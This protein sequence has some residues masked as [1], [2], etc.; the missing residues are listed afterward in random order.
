M[1][2]A[3]EPTKIEKPL[4]VNREHLLSAL[5]FAKGGL[6]Q[7]EIIQ[8]STCFIFKD[9]LI[10]TYNEK[11]CCR[12]PSPL[13]SNLT[14]AIPSAPLLEILGELPEEE[15]QVSLKN[16]Q[17]Q[18]KGRG[19]VAKINIEARIYLDVDSIE[20]PLEGAKG[21]GW[22]PLHDDFCEAISIVQQCAMFKGGEAALSCIHIHPQ[23]VEACDLA[24]VCFCRFAL[25]TLFPESVLIRRESVQNLGN[26]GA[27]RFA[28]TNG[29]VHFE[30]PRGA[31][32][33]CRRYTDVVDFPDLSPN[34][35]IVGQPLE[36]SKSLP[37]E[38]K[39]AQIFASPDGEDNNFLRIDV[40]QTLNGK[41]GGKKGEMRLEGKGPAG[42]YTCRKGA[43]YQG[44]DMTFYIPPQML[45][46]ILKKEEAKFSVTP[47]FLV[48]KTEKYHYVAGLAQMD[49]DRKEEQAE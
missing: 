4:T 40:Y 31:V 11:T 29:W 9:G 12:I 16:N 17:L 35:Q 6:A 19:R 25:S 44:E 23:W 15:L 38:L 14:A 45:L 47:K 34:V 49:P 37:D 28:I 20:Q 24:R 48:A 7:R 30:G 26:M 32:L 41:D 33:S 43:G 36:F 10:Q 3:L 2:L 13:G 39:R 22:T 27:S 18:L 42:S 21:E 1:E 5:D 8:Q 46:D